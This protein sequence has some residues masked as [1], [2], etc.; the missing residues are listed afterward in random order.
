MK[1]VLVVILIVLLF[2][3][4]LQQEWVQQILAGET[5]FLENAQ[6][7]VSYELLWLTMPLFILQGV[8]TFFPLV[9]LLVVHIIAFGLWEGI[10][11][12]WIGT[13]IGS[14]VC[15]YLGRFLLHDYFQRIWQRYEKKYRKWI[16]MSEDFGF[17]G[18]F[19]LRHIPVIPSNIISLVGAFSPMTQRAYIFS[20]I[21]GNLSMVWLYA[22]VSTGIIDAS[23]LL[24]YVSGYLIFIMIVLT[25]F[26]IHIKRGVRQ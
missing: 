23:Q 10:L 19:F 7:N 26:V 25:F 6:E 13:F 4:M 3:W 17:W 5:V 20:S 15:F 1:K 21:L 14:V 11:F 12:S 9:S 16:R 2:I 18:I 24:P 8:V 22:L